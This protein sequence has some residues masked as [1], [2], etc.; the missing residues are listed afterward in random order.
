MTRD[1]VTEHEDAWIN[2]YARRSSARY[3]LFCGKCR[4]AAVVE[5]ADIPDGEVWVCSTCKEA[6]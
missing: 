5:A 6:Q 3:E 2:R 1:E 4:T